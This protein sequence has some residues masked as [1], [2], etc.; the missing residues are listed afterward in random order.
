M[1][2]SSNEPTRRG[3]LG[4]AAPERDRLVALWDEGT[5]VVDLPPHGRVSIGR[6][7]DCDLRID[8]SSVSRRHALVHVGAPASIEDLGSS[9]GTFVAATRLEPHK[10]HPLAPDT[11]VRLGDV[12]LVLRSAA[13]EATAHETREPVAAIP[14]STGLEGF[15]AAVSELHAMASAGALPVVILGETGVGKG[16]LAEAIH[17]RS[18]RSSRRLVRLNC[19]AL[20]ETLLEN[21]LFGHERGA[22]TGAV[23][24]KPGLLEAADGGTL[25]LDEIGEMPLATQAKLL[26]VV[27]LG[28]V[29]RLGSL[30]PRKIDVRFIAATNR[31]LEALVAAGQFRRDL[32]FRLAGL[33]IRVPPLRERRADIPVLAATLLRDA[34]ARVGKAAPELSEEVLAR[35]V[36]H[37]WPGN[38]RELK[39]AMA[40]FALVGRAD[41][42]LFDA[43]GGAAPAAPEAPVARPRPVAGDPMKRLEEEMRSLAKQR[44]IDALADAGGNQTKAA[45]A[46]GVSRRTLTKRLNEFGLPRPRKR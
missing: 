5:A 16:V 7:E 34:C 22:Y 12:L 46:L 10:P 44:V 23:Q 37:S 9:N 2:E 29:L 19:A 24:A 39:N 25:L 38:V 36:G 1:H 43:P 13:P 40:R 42:A 14:G 35:L 11:L 6:A 4:G 28:E 32:Y 31:E 45:R 26:H 15:P 3:S 20:P 41:V 18:A 27:E 33:T 21:E 8:H 30:R 17:E